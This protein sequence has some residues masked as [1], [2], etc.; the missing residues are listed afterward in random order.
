VALDDV[1]VNVAVVKNFKRLFTAAILGK[2]S[3]NACRD[4]ATLV[5]S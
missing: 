4:A 1:A 3:V 5:I 2:L